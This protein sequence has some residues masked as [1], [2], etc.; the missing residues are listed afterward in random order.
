MPCV[1]RAK[2]VCIVGMHALVH[3]VATLDS[4]RAGS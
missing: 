4:I 3:S 1:D 2:S